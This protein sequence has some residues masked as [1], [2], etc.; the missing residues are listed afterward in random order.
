[1]EIFESLMKDAP[2]PTEEEHD[3]ESDLLGQEIEMEL[4]AVDDENPLLGDSHE[5][6]LTKAQSDCFKLIKASVIGEAAPADLQLDL[7]TGINRIILA[8]WKTYKGYEIKYVIDLMNKSCQFTH[9]HRDSLANVRCLV[10]GKTY[11]DQEIVY[12]VTTLFKNGSKPREIPVHKAFLP[13][14][15]ALFYVLH[16][17]ES[18][19][20]SV[21]NNLSISSADIKKHFDL[22]DSSLAF[23]AYHLP[24]SDVPSPVQSID[25]AC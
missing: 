1:M 14:C 10:T 24:V 7:L 5:E 2:A 12:L 22:L 19:A 18:L 8:H 4:E 9:V 15:Y 11:P 6:V 17:K 21:K 13:L 20:A 25:I 23:I 16:F 3:F